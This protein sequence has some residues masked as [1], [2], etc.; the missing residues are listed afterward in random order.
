MLQVQSVS[1]T[2]RDSHGEEFESHTFSKPDLNKFTFKP[3]KYEEFEYFELLNNYFLII[4]IFWNMISTVMEIK[5]QYD[6]K[7]NGKC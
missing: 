7:P 4:G 3:L 1:T 5:R 6:I 2:C